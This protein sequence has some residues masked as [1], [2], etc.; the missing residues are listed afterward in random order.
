MEERK[1]AKAEQQ[2]VVEHYEY[3][4]TIYKLLGIRILNVA[5]ARETSCGK[6]TRKSDSVS[7]AGWLA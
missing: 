1:R 2:R 4:S 7:V 6:S 5:I 3:M